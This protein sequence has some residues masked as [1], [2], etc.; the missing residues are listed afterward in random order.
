[1]K[2]ESKHPQAPPS[3]EEAIYVLLSNARQGVRHRYEK[4]E[5]QIQKSP[6]N[7]VLGAVATGYLLHRV[8]VRA[9][10]VAQIRVLSALTP[11]VLFLFGPPSSVHDGMMTEF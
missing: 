7:A 4:Y 3:M 10:L 6:R 2:T 5:S 8:P 11:P 1:M 9:I